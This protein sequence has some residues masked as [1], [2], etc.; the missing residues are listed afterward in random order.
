[1]ETEKQEDE[2]SDEEKPATPD[3][4]IAK[5]LTG[6]KDALF[7][8][9][10]VSLMGQCTSGLGGKSEEAKAID[11]IEYQMRQVNAHLSHIDGTIMHKSC[12]P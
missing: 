8:L 6:I 7:I 5:S 9:V 10:F 2:K 3:E 12:S 4:R 11:G 1:M